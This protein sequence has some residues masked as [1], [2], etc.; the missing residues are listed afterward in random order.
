MQ[1]EMMIGFWLMRIACAVLLGLAAGKIGRTPWKWAA[2]SVLLGPVVGLVSLAIA[3]WFFPVKKA[4][5]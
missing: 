2:V 4:V 3:F 5:A 1:T